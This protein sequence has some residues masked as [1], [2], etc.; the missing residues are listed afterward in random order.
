M[1]EKRYAVI[2][3]EQV[4]ETLESIFLSLTGKS[5]A[6]DPDGQA[7]RTDRKEDNA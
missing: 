4:E 1:A 3:M 2:S 7:S 6:Q 5:A